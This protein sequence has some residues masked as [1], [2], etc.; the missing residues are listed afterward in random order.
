MT[1][2]TDVTVDRITVDKVE[3][4]LNGVNSAKLI[5]PTIGLEFNRF[6]NKPNSARAV[7]DFDLSDDQKSYFSCQVLVDITSSVHTYEDLRT[8]PLKRRYISA[9]CLEMVLG[10]VRNLLI[11]ATT[12]AGLGSP[13]LLSGVVPSITEFLSEENFKR[14][15]QGSEADPEAD[16]I[17]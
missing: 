14:Y 11:H 9:V 1:E 3:W 2:L 6:E 4:D 7:C 10:H 12:L 13:V 15:D 17:T 5:D 16:P 8:S